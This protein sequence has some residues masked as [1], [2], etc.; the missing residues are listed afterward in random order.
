MVRVFLDH[1]TK[2]FK[3]EKKRVVAVDD[4]TLEVPDGTFMGLL[5]PSGCG[6][7]TTLRIIAGLETPT[8]GKVYFDEEEVT[9]WEPR[10][11]NVAMV[12]QFPVLYP[13]ITVYENI[14]LPL[15]AAKEPES[16]I[17]KKVKEIA[18]LMGITEIL[19]EKPI[20]LDVNSKQKISLAKALIRDPSVFIL[21]EP[22]TVLDPKARIELRTKL[23]KIQL[24]MKKTMIYVT[25]DQTESLT[26]AEKVA[27]MNAGKILQYDTPEALYDNPANT[28]VGWFIGNPGMNLIEC[29]VV[30]ENGKL[31]LSTEGGFRYDISFIA[32]ELKKLGQPKTVVLG[33]RPEFVEVGSGPLKAKCV[34]TEYVGNRII[35]H[36]ES[37]DRTLKAKTPITVR[38]RPGDTLRIDFVKERIKLFDPK[39]GNALL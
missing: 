15:R 37:Y 26:L 14:A 9:D 6:K 10:K 34:H 22:L 32:D 13:T 28:F 31:Y 23:K 8:K 25:H 29:D 21:D 1:V 16:E 5:G 18:E 24:G 19:N 7:T 30:E 39:T 27:V 17:R 35:L 12:F 4:V 2:I 33:I 36:L 3:G 11:R 20:K 38:A